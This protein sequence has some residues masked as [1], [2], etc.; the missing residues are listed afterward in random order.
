MIGRV[1]PWLL[2]LGVGW[3]F[4]WLR[5]VADAAGGSLPFVLAYLANS[6]GW[7]IGIAALIAGSWGIRRRRQWKAHRRELLGPFGWLLVGWTAVGWWSVAA[8]TDAMG[9]SLYFLPGLAIGTAILGVVY[10][11][12][13]ERKP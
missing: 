6:V 10:G 4:S 7:A 13:T 8:D 3:L 11:G 1:A 5:D 2:I 9:A 12:Q